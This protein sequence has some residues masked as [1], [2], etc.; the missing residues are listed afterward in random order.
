[1]EKWKHSSVAFTLTL[2]SGTREVEILIRLL[3]L[4]LYIR[5][6]YVLLVFIPFST[7]VSM[8]STDTELSNQAYF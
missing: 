5:L 4:K 8:F 2:L 1:M 6:V 7:H 3:M